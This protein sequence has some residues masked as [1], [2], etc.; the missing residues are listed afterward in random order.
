MATQ[1]LEELERRI[2][3]LKGDLALT[4]TAV[5]APDDAVKVWPVLVDDETCLGES[6][7]GQTA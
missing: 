4:L 3:Q 7:C 5:R 1:E 6:L 2:R